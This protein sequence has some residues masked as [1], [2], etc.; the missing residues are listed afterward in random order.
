MEVFFGVREGCLYI[1]SN[2]ELADKACL[3]AEDND[4]REAAKGKYLSASLD[5]GQIIE[6]YPGVAIMLKA[7]PQVREITDAFERVSVNSD[8]PQSMELS[9]HTN[10]P[11]KEII[12]NLWS[13]M[14]G[15][16][17]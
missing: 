11:I 6:S 10:K 1:A 7:L 2:T 12:Q 15:D 16:K 8:S 4:S 3:D 14:T 9:I 17:K 5:I 13:L